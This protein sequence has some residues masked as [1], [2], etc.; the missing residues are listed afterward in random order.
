ELAILREIWQPKY[1]DRRIRDKE[2]CAAFI[3][4][5]EENPVKRGL[6]ETASE[7]PFSSANRRFVRELDRFPERF[8]KFGPQRLKAREDDSLSPD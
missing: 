3:R 5:L 2:E 1:H 7:F 4:Y 6:V 8:G